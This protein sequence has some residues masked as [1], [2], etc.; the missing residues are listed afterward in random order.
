LDRPKR[1]IPASK[2]SCHA[3][4]QLRLGLR[5]FVSEANSR[6]SPESNRKETRLAAFRESVVDMR[7][8]LAAPAANGHGPRSMVKAFAAIRLPVHRRGASSDKSEAWSVELALVPKL[9]PV[10]WC[11]PFEEMLNR[12]RVQRSFSIDRRPRHSVRATLWTMLW[13]RLPTILWT[14]L[15]TR[16]PVRPKVSSSLRVGPANRS[17]FSRINSGRRR[18]GDL[19]VGC[20]DWSGDQSTTAGDQSTTAGD[21]STTGPQQG[22]QSTTGVI[23]GMGGRAANRRPETR[24]V[25]DGKADFQE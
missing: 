13:T 3:Q 19:A 23:G 11:S 9:Y 15:P 12:R 18:R 6:S 10:R 17:S 7:I 22:D 2:T 8:V 21:Q 25:P 5:Q 4:P 16:P 24:S 14:G 20:V 1:V